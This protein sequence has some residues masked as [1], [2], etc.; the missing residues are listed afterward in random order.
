MPDCFIRV[1]NCSIR[2]YRSFDTIDNITQKEFFNTPTPLPPPMW[3]IVAINY[4]VLHGKIVN[5][6]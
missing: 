3:R 2:E 5:E 4:K 1:F 6:Y